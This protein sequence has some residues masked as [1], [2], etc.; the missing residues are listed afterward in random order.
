MSVLNG[1]SYNFVAH[2]FS[3]RKKNAHNETMY[4]LN[5]RIRK[6]NSQIVSSRDRKGTSERKVTKLAVHVFPKCY[7]AYLIVLTSIQFCCYINHTADRQSVCQFRTPNTHQ[8]G[9]LTTRTLDLCLIICSV[10]CTVSC[11]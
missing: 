11:L 4:A 9:Q 5:A 1:V 2:L 3:V 6:V 8:I 7:F 10:F